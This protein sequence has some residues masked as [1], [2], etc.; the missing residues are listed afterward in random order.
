MANTQG[1]TRERIEVRNE[2]GTKKDQ[3][4]IDSGDP[5]F[6]HNSD[7]PRMALV[8]APLIGKNFLT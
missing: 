8:M 7:H 6:L 2:V 1:E 4:M 3:N 5:L